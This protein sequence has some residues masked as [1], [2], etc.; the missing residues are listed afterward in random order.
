MGCLMARRAG[1]NPRVV[2]VLAEVSAGEL[3]DRDLLARF[4]A[5]RDQ[6]AFAALVARH[7]GMVLGVC[8][9]VLPHT[10]DAEDACQAVFLLLAEK[11]GS[12]PWQASVAGWLYTTARKVAH[13]A[14]IAAERR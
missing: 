13:N 2:R 8:R 14:R 4:A 6:T 7:T 11:A 1:V 9:R 12:N 5:G 10:P 3:S